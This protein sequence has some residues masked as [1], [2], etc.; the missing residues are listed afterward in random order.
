MAGNGSSISPVSSIA[1]SRR[2]TLAR[3]FHFE[4]NNAAIIFLSTERGT[5]DT[6]ALKQRDP[7]LISAIP[8]S[9]VP[10]YVLVIHLDRAA[11]SRFHHV[12]PCIPSP[13]TLRPCCRF[14]LRV[15]IKRLYDSSSFPPPSRLSP[16]RRPVRAFSAL[17]FC[18]SLRPCEVHIAY[19]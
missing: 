19:I 5:F 15:L 17:F 13:R 3:A 18:R 16:P 4:G 12:P 2:E 10:V 8:S 6:G 7:S 11:L 1:R 9:R 14:R